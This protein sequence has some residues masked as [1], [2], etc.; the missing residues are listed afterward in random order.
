MPRKIRVGHAR[1]VRMWGESGA[2][3]MS[4]QTAAPLRGAKVAAAQG[5][6][7]VTGQ[8]ATLAEGVGG[9]DSDWV[10][11]STASG[12]AFAD[13]LDTTTNWTPSGTVDATHWVLADGTQD[14][15]SLDTSLKAHASAAGSLKFSVLNTDGPNSGNFAIRLPTTYGDGS[16]VWWSYRRRVPVEHAW[17]PWCGAQTA[18]KLSIL[19]HSSS[20]NQVNEVV[21]TSF[22]NLITGYHQNGSGSPSFDVASNDVCS[23]TNFMWQPEVDNNAAATQANSLYPLTGTNPDTGAAWTACEQ[24]SRRNG[25]LYSRKTAAPVRHGYGD[26]VSGGFREVPGEW[27]TYTHRLVISAM[28]GSTATNRF[29]LWAA[30]ED[31][32]YVRLIDASDVVLGN[33]PDYN[34]LWLLPYVTGRSTGG[35]SVSSVT[36]ISGVTVSMCGQGTP[37][38]AGSLEYVAL[39]GLFRFAAIGDTYGTARGYSVANGVT[40]I[41]LR[42]GSDG[43]TT[44]LS[45]GITLPTASIVLTN[46]SAFPTSGSVLIGEADTSASGTGE[47]HINYTGK[48]GNTLT[49]CTGGTGTKV[50]ASTV[51]V[52][53]F[54]VLTVDT[55]AA[56]PASG[57]TTATV[58]IAEGRADTQVNYQDAIVST[59]AIKAPGQYY[60]YD[61]DATALE[62]LA[63][64]MSAGEWAALT[65]TGV[66]TALLFPAS[67]GSNT[68][69]PYAVNLAWDSVLKRAHFIGTDHGAP[70]GAV[71]PYHVWFD[72]ITNTWTTQ[73][74]PAWAT[75]ALPAGYD[76]AHGY[77]LTAQNVTGRRLYRNPYSQTGTIRFFDLD[78]SDTTAA[79]EWS[80]LP[81][82]GVSIGSVINAIEFFPDRN[83]L[84]WFCADG[85]VREFSETT[86]TWATITPGSFPAFQ[87]GAGGAWQHCIYNPVRQEMLF[88]GSTLK[89]WTYSA[90]GVW[91]QKADTP[92]TYRTYDGSGYTGIWVVDPASGHYLI[93]TDPT[94]GTG[95]NMYSYNSATDTYS[96]ATAIPDKRL[97]GQYL[98]CSI[99]SAGVTLWA[100]A[101]RTV[102][103]G[104]YLYKHA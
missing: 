55:P 11:R 33:G 34:T 84:I 66:A 21:T 94:N 47:Q 22:F 69:I 9:T 101:Q 95:R 56:L 31:E 89:L 86:Q 81:S 41:N 44:S 78:S 100:Y 72:T 102:G 38:G 20:S 45:G 15:V 92:S 42:S 54:I 63:A 76:D 53:S 39:T 85:N 27:I 32:P 30:R 4:G 13:R 60:P 75:Q 50:T 68:I 14:H 67:S 3:A 80:T 7:A 43:A 90:A 93:L 16:T 74:N 5:S 79:A 52:S 91:S 8:S 25:G 6:Y 70:S 83:S 62:T 24:W 40:T 12:V 1:A 48:S 64:S 36:G 71:L 23:T 96:S 98:A 17:Q 58:S 49:G 57:T 73:T 82:A 51:Q 61:G 99:P 77:H 26:P 104:V 59:A 18:P 87:G 65:T 19:S 97:L 46:A 10:L 37:V 88:Y 35:R 103:A 2:Y 29:T 28:D